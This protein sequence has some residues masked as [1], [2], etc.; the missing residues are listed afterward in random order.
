LSFLYK[1]IQKN[2][3]WRGAET[4]A[5]TAISL[6]IAVSARREFSIRAYT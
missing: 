2:D 1:T 6:Q 3:D 4:E 5:S